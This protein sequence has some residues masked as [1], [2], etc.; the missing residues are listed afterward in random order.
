M[1]R[2]T[3]GDSDIAVS[4]LSWGCWRLDSMSVALTMLETLTTHGINFI[5]T[6]AIYGYGSPGGAGHAESVLGQALRKHSSSPDDW[7][8]ASKGGLDLP[9]PYNS[10]K[11]F[12]IKDCEA[13]LARLGL[14]RLDVYMIHRPDWLTGAEEV[15]LALDTLV[16]DGK[17]R[18]VGVS[19]YTPA[20]VDALR[21]HLNAPLVVNQIEFSAKHLSPLQDGTLDQC[22]QHS[23]T[24]MAWSPLGGGELLQKI[25]DNHPRH[26]WRVASQLDRIAAA[27]H[28]TR[29]QAALAFVLKTPNVMPIIGSQSPERV[30]EAIAAL[31]V[32]LSRREWYEICEA[33]FGAPMP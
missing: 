11:A 3:L 17:V 4:P 28:C 1:N 31:D 15:A 30:S 12:L 18:T 26:L 10:S 29:S 23:M 32:T 8:I 6:A 7:V 22:Q 24:A 25:D 14:D 2:I 9:T 13:S 20:Q 19:N 5:D 21:A 33:R 16:R 27:K